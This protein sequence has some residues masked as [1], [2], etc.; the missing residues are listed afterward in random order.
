MVPTIEPI[1]TLPL[2]AS[3]NGSVPTPSLCFAG[4]PPALYYCTTVWNDPPYKIVWWHAPTVAA[5]VLPIALLVFL[6]LVR[7][8]VSRPQG[9]GRLYCRGCNHEL[10]VDQ[11]TV[12]PYG[13]AI[14]TTESSRCPECGQRSTRGPVQG[15]SRMR[16]ATPIAAVGLLVLVCCSVLVLALN[17]LPPGVY[18]DPTWPWRGLEKALGSWSLV[19]RMPVYGNSGFKRIV[20]VPLDGAAPQIL[21]RDQVSNWAE[22]FV[23]PDGKYVLN[24]A[25]QDGSKL[26]IT[27]ADSGQR[28]TIEFGAEK[29]DLVRPVG[30][31]NDNRIVYA[32][33]EQRMT[34]RLYQ[35]YAVELE[36]GAKTLL[37]EV[38][39]EPQA[40]GGPNVPLNPR[41]VVREI[42]GTVR[43]ALLQ[44]PLSGGKIDSILTIPNGTSF[45]KF[46]FT[47]RVQWSSPIHWLPDGRKIEIASDF[48]LFQGVLLDTQTG[49]IAY[50]PCLFPYA[51]EERGMYVDLQL[52]GHALKSRQGKAIGILGGAGDYPSDRGF[53]VSRDGRWA[54]AYVDVTPNRRAG[55]S[56][57]TQA[58]IWVWDLSQ[59]PPIERDAPA[60]K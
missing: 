22:G 48:G 5:I 41:F 17:P 42:D 26:H 24:V 55:S 7:R 50:Q 21:L 11:A 29:F 8:Y 12:H 49:Q 54:A 2:D 52:E 14:W 40:A 6:W 57:D 32:Q 38:Q 47:S 33:F 39:P 45:M 25:F 9:K 51:G 15:S 20:R 37:A 10:S 13:P 34:K 36:S 46:P 53:A 16:R 19:R 27:R 58:E 59:L 28:R 60:R 44:M 18:P 3:P 31:S 43:W 30:F 35:L 4:D 23:S 1:L 56:P